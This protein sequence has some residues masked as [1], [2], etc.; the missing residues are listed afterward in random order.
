MTGKAPKLF[1]SYS[2]TSPAHEEWVLSLAT[3]LIDSGVDVILDKWD[4]KEGQDAFAFMEKMVTDPDITKVAMI[5]DKQ[6]SEKANERK[7][8][9]GTE[10]QIISPE[11]YAKQD[12]TKFVAVLPERDED[13][14]PYLPTYYCSRIFIDLSSMD[15]FNKGY[16]QLVRWI[17]DKPLHVKPELGAIPAFLT[18]NPQASL[19]TMVRHRRA[20]EAI[21]ENRPHCRGVLS[22][23][24]DTFADNLERFRIIKDDE[25]YDEKVVRNIE[26]FLPYRNEVIEIIDALTRYRPTQESWEI[27]HKFFEKLLPYLFRPENVTS[28]TECD[29]DNFRFEIHELFLYTIAILLRSECFDGVV[30]LVRQHYYVAEVSQIGRNGMESFSVI[31]QHLSSLEL[32]NKRLQ[33]KRISLHADLLKDRSKQSGLPFQYLMQA[34]FILLIRDYFDRLHSGYLHVWWPVTL[35]YASRQ[36]SSFEVFTRSQS[37]RY[38]ENI[39]RV[40]DIKTKDDLGELEEAFKK[41]NIQISDYRGEKSVFSLIGF[42]KLATLP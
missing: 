8:G 40:L 2:W 1:I 32:R 37:T 4:L 6:Y 27:V 42:D 39:K 31:R 19:Q 10:A 29:Y 36:Y 5:F 7:G 13:G 41:Q 17:Y 25:E 34:D 21:R 33:L 3:E 11:I 26:E 16:E 18:D 22:E 23:Y 14:K 9:V 35:L 28:Y 38:F 24:F 20:L 30:H 15:Q 12:Q